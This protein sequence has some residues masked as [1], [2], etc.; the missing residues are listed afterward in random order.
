MFSNK[1]DDKNQVGQKQSM[2][3]T[4][5]DGPGGVSGSRHAL[6]DNRIAKLNSVGFTWECNNRVNIPWEERFQD[7]VAFRDEH[8]HTRVPRKYQKDP[9]LGEWCHTQRNSLKQGLRCIFGERKDMLD[10]IGFE[11]S[12]ERWSKK[13]WEERFE[14][15]RKIVVI[16]SNEATFT[17]SNSGVP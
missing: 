14:Q 5:N 3:S 7:L 13:S 17:F 8:G 10:S 6:N 11:W 4:H 1:D 12:A 2:T 15:V 16:W 9:A